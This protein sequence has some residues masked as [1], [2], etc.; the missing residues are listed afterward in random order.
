MPV[1]QGNRQFLPALD[2]SVVDRIEL[3]AIGKNILEP[4]P[5]GHRGL[6][7]RGGRIRVVLKQLGWMRTVVSQ[8]EASVE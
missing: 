1:R 5:L 6:Q 4:E 3:I 7:Q 2:Q 8:I